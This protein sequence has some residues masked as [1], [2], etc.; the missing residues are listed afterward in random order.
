MTFSLLSF[1]LI[2]FDVQRFHCSTPSWSS[3]LAVQTQCHLP[4]WR[5]QHKMKR[6]RKSSVKVKGG[7]W[8][9]H[10]HT[11]THTHTHI[12]THTHTHTHIHTYTHVHT[13]AHQPYT[14]HFTWAI[15]KGLSWPWD[16]FMITRWGF[17]ERNV[18]NVLSA[19]V[20]GK[21]DW[22]SSSRWLGKMVRD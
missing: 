11:H 17:W 14:Q 21:H 3:L 19:G 13:H 7:C 10:A 20:S 12:H 18:D 4:V 15:Q 8:K 16:H 1:A 22:L 6:R 9:V 2:L 5:G